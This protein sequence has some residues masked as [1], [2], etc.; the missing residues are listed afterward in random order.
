MLFFFFRERTEKALTDSQS[1][2]EELKQTVS[3]LETAKKE[4]EESFESHLEE[5]SQKV[6]TM[7]HASIIIYRSKHKV[8]VHS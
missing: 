1:R 7:Q 6:C 2:E 4:V 3:D 8:T 5:A